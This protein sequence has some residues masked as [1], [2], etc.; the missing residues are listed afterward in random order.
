M[1]KV[2]P[3]VALIFSLLLVI[4]THAQSMSANPTS[5]PTGTVVTLS[6]SVTAE[7]YTCFANGAQFASGVADTQTS[8]TVSQTGG[9]VNFT[10]DLIYFD[11][12]AAVQRSVGATFTVTAPAIP[13]PNTGVGINIDPNAINPQLQTDPNA[14]NPQ[15]QID[16]NAIQPNA[17]PGATGGSD[18][19]M[20]GVPD[21][22]D[23]CP[24]VSGQGSQYGGVS[25]AD[26]CPV[27][28]DGDG[29]NDGLDQCPFDATTTVPPCG[30]GQAAP[31]TP[32]TT[33]PQTSA[34]PPAAAPITLP[35][36]ACY[37]ATT[38]STRVNV[39]QEPS[40]SAA[41]VGAIEVNQ[42][43]LVE[44][45]VENDIGERWYDVTTLTGAIGFV[46][47]DVVRASAP[48]DTLTAF[49]YGDG[50]MQF[51][52]GE[53]ACTITST[54]P[55]P[56][57]AFTDVQ[58]RSDDILP[59]IRLCIANCDRN[60]IT[61][62]ATLAPN[63]NYY[64]V[65]RT[66]SLSEWTTF[67]DQDGADNVRDV[68][69]MYY[70]S[71][72]SPDQGEIFGYVPNI[73][74]DATPECDQLPIEEGRTLVYDE[75]GLIFE[76]VERVIE[77]GRETGK[78]T[79]DGVI[80]PTVFDDCPNVRT[81]LRED[82]PLYLYMDVAESDTPCE[83]G[84]ALLEGLLFEELPS[85]INQN[86]FGEAK[87]C[88]NDFLVLVDY[89]ERVSRIDQNL[90]NDINEALNT[91]DDLC[92]VAQ[93]IRRGQMPSVFAETVL[94]LELA[95]AAI[96]NTRPDVRGVQTLASYAQHPAYRDF[97]NDSEDEMPIA[98]LQ[99][100]A[101]GDSMCAQY[102]MLNRVGSPTRQTEQF[103]Q[104]LVNTCNAPRLFGAT[105]PGQES[106]LVVTANLQRLN[107]NFETWQSSYTCDDP[108]A[109]NTTAR[110]H[111]VVDQRDADIAPGAAQCRPLAREL[112]ANHNRLTVGELYAIFHAQDP[113]EE[114]Q[115][116][117]QFDVPPLILPEFRNL[118]CVQQSDA[119]IGY[120]AVW[121]DVVRPDGSVITRDHAYAVKAALASLDADQICGDVPLLDHGPSAL[122]EEDI[123]ADVPEVCWGTALAV[124][125]PNPEPMTFAAAVYSEI[126][127]NEPP[128]LIP[129]THL[130]A[131]TVPANRSNVLQ[132]AAYL[133]DYRQATNDAYRLVVRAT[134]G[135][136]KLIQFGEVDHAICLNGTEPYNFPDTLVEQ[137]FADS[138][139]M[140]DALLGAS[141][142]QLDDNVLDV[143]FNPLIPTDPIEQA[144]ASANTNEQS[145]SSG[146]YNASN[147]NN[148]GQAS[149]AT[150]S[151]ATSDGNANP[152]A[153]PAS[154]PNAAQL[155]FQSVSRVAHAT[156]QSG[157]PVYVQP[158][159]A[160]TI[161]S[162]LENAEEDTRLTLAENANSSQSFANVSAIF[163][164]IRN[165]QSDLYQL[166]DGA[167]SPLFEDTPTHERVP[168]LSPD[169]EFLAYIRDDG[170]TR[171]L[172]LRSLTNEVEVTRLQSSDEL[173]LLPL[174]MSYT[175]DGESIWLT[176][177]NEAGEV[178][179]YKV[180]A[181]SLSEPP[182]LV[183]ANAATPSFAPNGDYVAMIRRRPGRPIEKPLTDI[184]TY[185]IQ[186]GT[187]IS[188]TGG[189][190]NEELS[191][192]SP[193][194]AQDSL[195]L[196]FACSPLNDNLV[197]FYVYGVRGV[198]Q[199]I[200]PTDTT[201][202][203]WPGPANGLY[204]YMQGNHVYIAPLEGGEGVP[205]LTVGEDA[206][207][208]NVW[209]NINTQPVSS[210]A[211]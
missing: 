129:E 89:V 48:C 203:I 57:F 170:E 59:D 169:G 197:G 108:Y 34:N 69:F 171:S 28:S 185:S 6:F 63:R 93:T 41:V 190:D 58:F 46:R 128:T 17:A 101:A 113:C 111:P 189:D 97:D 103:Y 115:Q 37:I 191:C 25:G 178:G 47:T 32:P 64:P 140:A 188:I 116:F 187:E 174:P 184:I 73:L 126:R 202:S 195:N 134:S 38:G 114:I 16:P 180:P 90:L 30:Q 70:V 193:R 147:G 13:Q 91:T 165:G 102:G 76:R 173:R 118:S 80:D 136:Y 68:S 200:P 145:A 8:Y 12:D 181:R 209:W 14:L 159:Q 78:T 67:A 131:I 7:Q 4:P 143:P 83:T 207:I 33:Q 71:T 56:V 157:T 98:L 158:V 74:V 36:D 199:V 40:V 2:F 135:D 122:T 15:P 149:P 130:Q 198:E 124:R 49:P 10:C 18:A 81:S 31:Q 121:G 167:L 148:N 183:V 85:P 55:I 182:Q 22:T 20:D 75:Q 109:A 210:P 35:N 153:Q 211:N 166:E 208:Q 77:G 141:R 11:G 163:E 66:Q 104:E 201:T 106:A 192:Y 94:Q 150:S 107:L 54:Q 139:A 194:F 53:A 164:V 44:N 179:V 65:A 100:G 176:M 105:S 5:G 120:G 172:M 127:V 92:G 161:E 144:N 154:N 156:T 152:P 62:F 99:R 27:D 79:I 132:F 23:R 52:V 160:A 206:S 60:D 155:G 177:E 137:P 72:F 26:G 95:G 96:C 146:S 3:V 196:N 39:R 186:S 175:P 86:W 82:L 87:D 133:P 51:L 43:Y 151:P 168:T 88:P 138:Q 1:K 119:P 29:T 204:S 19:D 50:N 117:I 21:Q 123:S 112:Q 110:P 84:Q 142:P 45:V 42:P 61:A 125:N 162:A 24:Y 9:T 205:V